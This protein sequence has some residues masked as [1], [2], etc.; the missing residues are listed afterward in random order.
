MA[1]NPLG[2][3]CPSGGA[4]YTCQN[5]ATEFLGCC[6]SDPCRDGSGRCPVANLRPASFP[7]ELYY[8]IPPQECGSSGAGSGSSS[9]PAA[10]WYTCALTDPP[11]LG[12]CTA[13][14]CSSGSCPSGS[15]AAAKLN[16]DA[17]AR[18]PFLSKSTTDTASSSTSSSKPTTTPT[19]PTSS[20]VIPANKATRDAAGGNDAAAEEA[21]GL[22]D[23]AIAGIAIAGAL[24]VIALAAFVMY[25]W[26]QKRHRGKPTSKRSHRLSFGP[27]SDRGSG[28]EPAQVQ[29]PHSRP[30][31]HVPMFSPSSH[32]PL[33]A[34]PPPPPNQ[35]ANSPYHHS[36]DG[37]AS[38]P[39]SYKS[40]TTREEAFAV[41]Y[42]P[43]NSHSH[44]RD[45][46]QVPGGGVAPQPL[47]E[48]DNSPKLA[49]LSG[50]ETVPMRASTLAEL[51]GTTV[52]VRMQSSRH[53]SG[54][55]PAWNHTGEE[56]HIWQAPQSRRAPRTPSQLR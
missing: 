20:H 12:C 26:H 34:S 4:F 16:S 32:G 33:P 3:T 42:R 45:T 50:G 46:S 49:E 41:K 39:L 38:P 25:K 2:I 17:G 40:G 29:A 31:S 24:A 30:P 8:D 35:F 9:D 10:L 22:P 5:N 6:T 13:N 51:P 1:A 27:V 11:F 47:A 7:A 53:E 28:D 15:L 23:G 44:S 18:S 55:L 54:V 14:P 56:L 52:P 19:S 36:P 37:L 43:Y 21:K 48:L